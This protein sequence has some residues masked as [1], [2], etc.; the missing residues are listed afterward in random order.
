[1]TSAAD[2]YFIR[3]GRREDVEEI[4]TLRND[5][6]QKSTAI[7]TTVLQ[8]PDEAIAWWDE[9]IGRRAVYV[10]ECDG[11]VAGFASWS[12]W[13][14]KEGYR[15][16]GEDSVYVAGEHHGRGLGRRLLATLIDGARESGLHVM[17]ADI[18]SSNTAS[19]A[20]HARLGFET[21]GTLREI[22]T[23]FNRWLDL[24]I[25]RLAL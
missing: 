11:Q 4:R 23:K 15:F 21:V 2:P 10:A 18:E 13:R 6:I 22:G 7:W 17:L 25:M 3:P 9:L 20:L 24:T 8:P 19:I 5:A 14:A 1:M 16:T 12:P